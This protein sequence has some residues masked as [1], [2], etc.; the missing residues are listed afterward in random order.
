MYFKCGGIRDSTLNCPGY[1]L[2]IYFQGCHKGC[3]GCHNPQFQDPRGGVFKDTDDIIEMIEKADIYDSLIFVG[4]EPLEQMDATIKLVMRSTLYNIL[5]TGWEYECIP[6]IVRANMDMI[7]SGP[8]IE[9]NA[10]NGFPASSNQQVTHK[11]K[12][13]EA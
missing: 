3:K 4:G 5:Y 9:E 1:G 6:H 10:T 7:I 2:E 13:D 8:Y 11:R 12:N